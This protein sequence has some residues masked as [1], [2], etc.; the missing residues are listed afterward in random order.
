VHRIGRTARAGAKGNAIS[1]VCSDREEAI[2][3][4]A[5]GMQNEEVRPFSFKLSAV[6][7]KTRAVLFL[8]VFIFVK[9]KDFVI[10]WRMCCSRSLATKSRKLAPT[11]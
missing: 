9:K 3:N 11:S 4:E 1:F 7:G 2:L 10:E 5:A 8:C 6:E